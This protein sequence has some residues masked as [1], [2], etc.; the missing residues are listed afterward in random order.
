MGGG[1]CRGF[2]GV[3]RVWWGLAGVLC[4]AI[5]VD[6]AAEVQACDL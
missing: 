6:L 3:R 5:G 2:V 4:G 1:F